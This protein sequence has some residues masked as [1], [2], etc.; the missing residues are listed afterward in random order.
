[1]DELIEAGETE[2]DEIE[3]HVI[4]SEVQRILWEDVPAVFLFQPMFIDSCS[5]R[6]RNWMPMTN[7]RI[8][9]RDVWLADENG[10]GP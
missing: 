10:G 3:R 4:Y 5:I 8:S 9:L 7:G 1:M 2:I 6:A